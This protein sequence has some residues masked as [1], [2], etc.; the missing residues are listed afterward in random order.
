M[1]FYSYA[2][3][4][5]LVTPYVA[6]SW[7]VVGEILFLMSYKSNVMR[8]NLNTIWI[9][10][11]LFLMRM[12]FFMHKFRFFFLLVVVYV[13]SF[14][15]CTKCHFKITKLISRIL[16]TFCQRRFTSNLKGYAGLWLQVGVGVYPMAHR[17]N[18]FWKD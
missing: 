8:I 12:S 4:V 3:C 14:C 11:V 9:D 1:S 13:C 2:H 16:C 15:C 10:N 6:L 5:F 7:L 17:Q 18:N